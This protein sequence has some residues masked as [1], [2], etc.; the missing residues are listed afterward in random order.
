MMNIQV[1]SMIGAAYS[2]PTAYG[3]FTGTNYCVWW[4]GHMFFDQKMMSLFSILF[5]AG[6]ALMTESAIRKTGKAAGLHYRRMFWLLLFG[7]CHAYL[8][9]AGDILVAYAMCGSLVFLVRKWNPKILF[10]LGLLLFSVSS[11]ITFGFQMSVPHFP[12]ETI[13][14]FENQW[15]PGP[16]TIQSETDAYRGGWFKQMEYRAFMAFWMQTFLFAIWTFW[17]AGGLMLIGV[18]LF[19]WDVITASQSKKFYIIMAATGFAIGFPLVLMGIQQN[20]AHEW[21]VLY[22]FFEG[23]QYNYWGSLFIALGYLATVC[24]LSKLDA[25]PKFLKL[26]LTSVGQMAL[27]NYLTQSVIATLIFY[28]HGLGYFGYASRTQQFLIVIGI[29]IFQMVYSTLWLKRFR[30]GP[31]EWLWRSLTY[32]KMQPMTKVNSNA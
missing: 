2:N 3:D 20:T 19:K 15:K 25:L 32:W 17:R 13:A 6:I 22:S 16:E 5:G 28:G 29:W 26:A 24:L 9:W 21:N 7:L 8:I 30:F 11:L 1:M 23:P 4:L 31:M 12:D 27:T 10:V 18:A 14:E